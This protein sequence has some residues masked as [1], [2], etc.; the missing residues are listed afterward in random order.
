M[1]D[2]NLHVFELA[3]TLAAV[4]WDWLAVEVIEAIVRGKPTKHLS[5]KQTPITREVVT[6]EAEDISPQER[7]FIDLGMEPIPVKEQIEF[8]ANYVFDRLSEAIAMTGASLQNLERI[9]SES[10]DKQIRKND[11]QGVSLTLGLEE[12]NFQ[13]TSA[14]GDRLQPLLL[15]LRSSLKEWT[16][17]TSPEEGH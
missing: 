13:F 10:P 8:A 14:D 7:Q 4:G 16:T 2:I 17:S 15:A 5:E 3:E 12:S 6:W 9:A 1:G 11:Q